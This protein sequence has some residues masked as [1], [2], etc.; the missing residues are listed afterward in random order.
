MENEDSTDQ[1]ELLEEKI[2]GLIQY[3]DALKKEKDS[4]LDKSKV[5][6][7]RIAGFA[8]QCVDGADLQNTQAS[9]ITCQHWKYAFVEFLQY[10]Q[11]MCR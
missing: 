8:S 1:F 11:L 3:L 6:D 7:E 2:N 10:K 9:P 5:Q 4:L